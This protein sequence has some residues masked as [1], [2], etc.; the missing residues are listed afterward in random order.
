MVVVWAAQSALSRGIA[1]FPRPISGKLLYNSPIQLKK[2]PTLPR[3]LAMAD[4]DREQIDMIDALILVRRWRWWI[5]AGA[6]LGLLL[7]VGYVLQRGA[8]YTVRVPVSINNLKFDEKFDS[9]RVVKTFQAALSS[10]GSE[11]SVQLVNSKRAPFQLLPD[12]TPGGF[13]FF[14]Q[15]PEVGDDA[16][17]QRAVTEFFDALA[18]RY[19][20][21]DDGRSGEE[22]L[23]SV[24]ASRLHEIRALGDLGRLELELIQSGVRAGIQ[25]SVLGA[26]GAGA[27][28]K[29]AT[30]RAAMLLGVLRGAKSADPAEISAY[31]VRI[32]RI[33]EQAEALAASR[34]L[35]RDLPYDRLPDFK[36]MGAVTVEG[37]GKRDVG[38]VILGSLLGGAA[39]LFAAAMAELLRRNRARL[40]GAGHAATPKVW[41][42]S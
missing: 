11:E 28:T 26:V 4:A 13:L 39:G 20:S 6:S 36:I 33:L 2:L 41:N 1:A 9:S 27:N 22:T 16:A 35:L 8:I 24:P 17:L 25:P 32:V 5:L 34:A 31:E 3:G 7:A 15:I 23:H 12:G 21:K 18:N 30:D 38:L 19:N 42:K 29:E 14:M 37:Q 40:R 10:P